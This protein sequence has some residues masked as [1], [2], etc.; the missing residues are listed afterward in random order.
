MAFFVFHNRKAVSARLLGRH[1]PI[2]D[3]EH[4]QLFSRRSA[5]YML[6]TAGFHTVRL[7]VVFNRYPLSYWLKLLPLPR[8]IKHAVLAATS[9]IQL[10]RLPVT[11][12]AGNLAA[13]AT[14]QK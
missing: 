10:G 3:I 2:Y 4:L 6:R 13:F 5:E 8:A 9:A 1:S 14:V 7:K 11:L 12:P